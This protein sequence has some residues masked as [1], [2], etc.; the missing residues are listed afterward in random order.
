[1]AGLGLATTKPEY[2]AHEIKID[3]ARARQRPGA[4]QV[5]ADGG[6]S[7][8]VGRNEMIPSLYCAPCV[9]RSAVAALCSAVLR[10]AALLS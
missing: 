6:R 8:A 10:C 1:M 7:K 4:F 3:G 2:A 9:Y 5:P